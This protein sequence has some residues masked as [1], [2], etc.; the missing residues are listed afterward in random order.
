MGDEHEQCKFALR[1]HQDS[2]SVRATEQAV[3]EFIRTS[4]G[5]HLSISGAS[6]RPEGSARPA[7]GEHV[8]Q[9]EAQFKMALGTKV[10]LKQNAKGGGRITIHF[11]DL[12]EF[13]RLQQVLM[14][15]RAVA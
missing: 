3:Q 1:I 8:T 11:K 14:A 6:S 2:L 7:S 13:E 12:Q 9:L 10:D 5:E 4:D 15:H